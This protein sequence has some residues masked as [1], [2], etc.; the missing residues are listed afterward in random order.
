MI[1]TTIRRDRSCQR[2]TNECKVCTSCQREQTSDLLKPNIINIVGDEKRAAIAPVDGT[3][4]IRQTKQSSTTIPTRDRIDW[5]KIH[6][7]RIQRINNCTT[8]KSATMKRI[9]H[10]AALVREQLVTQYGEQWDQAALNCSDSITAVKGIIYAIYSTRSRRIYIGQTS[11]TAAKRFQEHIRAALRGD[12]QPLYQS[13]RSLGWHSFIIVPLEII[14]YHQWRGNGEK[15]RHHATHREIWWM[16]HLHTYVNKGWNHRPHGY[17]RTRRAKSNPFIYQR[18]QL[19]CDPTPLT[20][21]HSSKWYGSRH[22]LNRAD[23]IYRKMR[24]QLSRLIPI[25]TYSHRSLT[26]L[27]SFIGSIEG[28]A[29]Y[30]S[31]WSNTLLRYLNRHLL[32]RHDAIRKE[33]ETPSTWIRVEWT[34]HSLRYASLKSHMLSPDVISEWP[35]SSIDIFDNLVVCKK[36]SKPIGDSICNFRKV[37]RQLPVLDSDDACYCRRY[38]SRYRPNGGCVYTGDLSIVH[39]TSLEQLLSYGPNH[40][41]HRNVNPMIAV[42]QGVTDFIAYH[43]RTNNKSINAFTSWRVAL[44]SAIAVS[45]NHH[46]PD[47]QPNRSTDPLQH[48]SIVKRLNYMMRHLVFVP[49][50]KASSNIAVVCKS[51][52]ANAIRNELC[53]PN[54][55][56]KLVS[57]SISTITDRHAVDLGKRC[58][59]H[60]LPYLYALPKLH[61]PKIAWRFIAASSSCTTQPLSSLL[62]DALRFIQTSLRHK[63]DQHFI[64]TGVKRYF[65]VDT[66]NEISQYCTRYRR[67]GAR[68]NWQLHTGDFSTMFT[69]IPHHDLIASMKRVTHEA[70]SHEA[71]KSNQPLSDLTLTWQRDATEHCRWSSSSSRTTRSKSVPAVCGLAD[72]FTR[73]KTVTFTLKSLNDAIA[74]LVQNTY[75]INAGSIYKQTVGIP[76]GT[77]CAPSLANLFLYDYESRFIDRNPIIAPYFKHT[78]RYIDDTLSMDNPYWQHAVTN[79]HIDNGGSMYHSSLVFNDTSTESADARSVHFLGMTINGHGGRLSSSIYDRRETF[80]FIV[81]RYPHMASLIPITIPYGVF[82]G[83]L[84]RVYHLCTMVHSFINHATLVAARLIGNGCRIK[85]LVHLFNHYLIQ[86]VDK[87]HGVT[88]NDIMYRWRRSLRAY[89][90]TI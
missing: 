48:P 58:G 21:S 56:Y 23:F 50:D 70:W 68:S 30:G 7:P 79:E 84:H 63:D 28:I 76:M 62:S 73:D 33:K 45:L 41:V 55:A 39:N 47:P 89:I 86:H 12:D 75:L 36:L 81:R 27:H 40:R 13:I 32:I 53:Q 42:T 14:P 1:N 66:A 72:I 90:T 22:W 37:A 26:R 38:P 74:Y 71:S 80:P 10:H 15:F 61:K 65:I 82:V 51:L 43:A 4:V 31:S 16:S 25:N 77:N 19:K 24:A 29:L 78:F 6:T 59:E 8:I 49:V 2:C 18:R 17:R 34:S 83:Q 88:H 3:I 87:Y 85:R 20:L 69:T 52:Y 5:K 60:K 64:A 35:C 11:Q 9:R 67:T 54:G 46:Y 57:D 44:L